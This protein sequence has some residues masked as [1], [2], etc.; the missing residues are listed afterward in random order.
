MR[1]HCKFQ[2]RSTLDNSSTATNDFVRHRNDAGVYTGEAR[3][4]KEIHIPNPYSVVT[5]PKTTRGPR[6]CPG[7]PMDD[8][9]YRNSMSHRGKPFNDR[10]SSM[11]SSLRYENVGRK[12]N[13]L[14]HHET[15]LEYA[16]ESANSSRDSPPDIHT[17]KDITRRS[18]NQRYYSSALNDS[19][20]DDD[21]ANMQI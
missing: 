18:Q 1:L 21:G 3:R 5:A 4:S 2:N 19:T 10:Y 14:Y 15:I 12:R 13:E 17:K 7:A 6:S 20:D 11:N 9:G 8:R 16:S